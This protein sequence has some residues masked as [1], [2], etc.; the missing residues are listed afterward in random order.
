MIKKLITFTVFGENEIY[1]IGAIKN[2][3]LAQTIYPDW[4]CRFYIFSECSKL[5]TELDKFENVETVLI[6]KKGG[7]YST[8][9]RFLPLEEPDVSYFISRDTDS[10]LSIR[11]KE[12]VY[13]WI[14]SNK[15]FHIMKDHPYHYTEE[16]PILAGM[17][18]SKGNVFKSIKTY[19]KN[20]CENQSDTK[21]IDQ[22]L[23]YKFY[24]EHVK[25]DV[26]T[27]ES[28]NFPSQRNYERDKIYF[29]G[30]PFDGNDN[31]YGDWEKD[32]QKIG[33]NYE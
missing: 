1:K 32:L 22:K 14:E 3:I 28:N 24:H 13:E 2:A 20:F 16:F 10:R 7:F 8:L 30:Q 4:I 12:A 18:G 21:G 23:L 11:E 19:I 6:N 33:I 29:I 17:W 31:F 27:H 9:Y 25:N 5:K 15:T 26:I